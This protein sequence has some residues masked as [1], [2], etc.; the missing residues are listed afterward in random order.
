M[1]DA[2][3]AVEFEP[4]EEPEDSLVEQKTAEI[5]DKE[6]RLIDGVLARVPALVEAGKKL[7]AKAKYRDGANEVLREIEKHRERLE[8]LKRKNGNW[9]GNNNPASQFAKTYGQKAHDKMG[10]DFRCNLY[11]QSG[12]PGLGKD[13]PDCIL[14]SGKED[15]WVLEFKPKG[16]TGKIKLD[17][18][19]PAVRNYYQ[20]R[21]RREEDA[22]SQ[23]GGHA[24]QSLIEA[25]CRKDYSK[26]KKDDELYF[27]S[28]QEDYDR[29]KQQYQCEQ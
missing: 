14:I 5:I 21:M 12:F 26:D 18:Y 10:A 22:S 24:L 27:K 9:G 1:W 8:K 16:Y 28:R 13:R 17:Q 3:C 2:W 25:N 20:E 15:C 29:C 11:D 6:S 4:N 23:L 7:A 19:L